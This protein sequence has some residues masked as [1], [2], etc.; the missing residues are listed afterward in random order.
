MHPYRC[1]AIVMT[2]L[3]L[4]PSS[5]GSVEASTARK[6]VA[7]SA[8]RSVARSAERSVARIFRLDRVRD[9]GTRV[10]SLPKARNVFRYVNT[11][12]LRDALRRGFPR[13][14]HFT[15]RATR[16]RPLSIARARER[17]GIAAPTH[18]LTANLAK[19]TRVRFAKTLGGDRGV[20]E[21]T[22]AQNV[23]ARAIRKVVRLR[24]GISR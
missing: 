19:G 1:A 11:R 16:G 10:V 9:A 14:T 2:V 7:R 13:R 21:I 3:L 8:A 12:G 23:G 24:A 18:R 15:A 4:V 20:G 17:F 5:I 6:A 22:A